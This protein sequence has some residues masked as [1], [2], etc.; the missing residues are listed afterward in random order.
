MCL[1]ECIALHASVINTASPTTQTTVWQLPQTAKLIEWEAQVGATSEVLP[2]PHSH[3]Q[4][5]TVT[6]SH[7]QQLKSRQKMFLWVT[8]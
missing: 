5:H 1:K 7:T 4:S 2:N 3:T 8:S 6:Q